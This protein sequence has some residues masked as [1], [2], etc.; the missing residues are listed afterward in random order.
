[1]T[2]LPKG[3]DMSDSYTVHYHDSRGRWHR[4]RGSY[5]TA[6]AALREAQYCGHEAWEVRDAAG[7][8]VAKDDE[9]MRREAMRQT[10]T[11]ITR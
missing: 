4:R 9:A 1:M 11:D 10:W 8:I 2:Y 7:N 5:D 3:D 6:S